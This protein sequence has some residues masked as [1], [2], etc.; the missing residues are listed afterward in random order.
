MPR[1][2]LLAACHSRL[3]LAP[4]RAALFPAPSPPRDM[5]RARGFPSHACHFNTSLVFKMPSSPTERRHVAFASLHVGFSLYS[6]IRI[7]QSI[8]VIHY[9]FT[10]TAPPDLFLP[11]TLKFR[12]H[13][14]LRQAWTEWSP[15]QPSPEAPP[16]LKVE[17]SLPFSSPA[18]DL[19]LLGGSS[20]WREPRP[21]LLSLAGTCPEV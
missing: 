5:T 12:P 3:P 13:S 6:I 18:A 19:S 21:C 20:Q 9:Q 7:V 1:S 4:S 2:K 10:L 15:R 16:K 17:A 8:S 14:T 11:S